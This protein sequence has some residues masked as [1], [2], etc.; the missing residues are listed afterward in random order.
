MAKAGLLSLCKAIAVECA[1]DN[2]RCNCVSPGPA[3]TQQSTDIVGPE[4]MDKWRQ[5]GFPAVPMGRLAS[6]DDIAEAFLFLASDAAQYISGINLPV[7]G[8]LL[9]QAYDVPDE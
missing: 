9:A 1:P 3:D 7:D 6:T 4:L 2:I 5:N 8:A